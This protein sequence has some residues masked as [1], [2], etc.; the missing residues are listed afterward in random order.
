MDLYFFDLDKT[1]YTYDF[2]YR[3]PELARLTGASQY[4]L[5]KFWWA[6]GFE[7]RA[8]A[9]E[10]PTSDEYLDMFA[11]TTGGRRLSLEEWADA[12]ALAMTRIDGSIEALRRAAGFG[13][14]SL[15][16]NNPSALRDALPQLA[17]DVVEILGD[18]ILVSYM[19]GARK[20]TPELFTRALAHYGVAADHAFLA[21]D[22][23]ANVAGARAV[24]ITAHWLEY[25]DGV[26]QTDALH[27]ALNTFASR[28]R[29]TS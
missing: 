6:A 11:R 8:E 4:H 22:T 7:R 28:P 5:A 9:G 12:R 2:R 29:R 24:G 13:T 20:P 19:L 21:D 15:L 26:P 18:N 25:V 27:A 1:L 14:V 17:P 16:S 23:F 3:L 10:W